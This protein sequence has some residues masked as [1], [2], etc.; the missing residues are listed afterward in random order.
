M[1]KEETST[2]CWEW[3]L[4]VVITFAFLAVLALGIYL[5]AVSYLV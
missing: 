2:P 5:S 1:A 3:T 4:W